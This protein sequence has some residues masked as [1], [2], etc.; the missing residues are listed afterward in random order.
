MPATRLICPNDMVLLTRSD[1]GSEWLCRMCGRSY[2]I[3]DNVVQ[4]LQ[5]TDSFYEGQYLNQVHYLPR[6]ER[7]SAVWPL[8]LINNSYL[9]RVRTNVLAGSTVL[10]LGCAGGIAYFARRYRM[11]G[12]DV[13]LASLKA[14]GA[15]YDICIQADASELIP[16][17]DGSVDAVASSYFWEHIP[18]AGKTRI[19]DQL[20]R[21]LKP[22]GKLIFLYDVE[23][24]NPLV[25]WLRRRDPAR[26]H[27]EFIARDGHLGYQ[28]G[29]ENRK[30]FEEAGFEVQE[31]LGMERS[32][33]Q[34][35][36]VYFKMRSWESPASEI[37]S[38]LT[39]VE[40]RSSTRLSYIGLLRTIDETVGRL[41]PDRWSRI[42]ISVCEKRD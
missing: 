25:A 11:V 24:Q 6:S 14:A 19:L 38:L 12:L 31:H 1:N 7:W 15:A 28:T 36:S 40:N 18:P 21:L 2:P 5:T 16:L 35:T 37:G 8:W 3:V 10:E 33:L 29:E 39:R 4:F 27:A 34:S 13:S 32:P 22:A 26:Y 41:L 9:W 20:R 42:A 23:T 30:L 17:E